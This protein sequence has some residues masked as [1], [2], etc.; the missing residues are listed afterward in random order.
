[1]K[2]E[3]AIGEATP[4]YLYDPEVPTRIHHYIPHAKMIAILR[5]PVDRAYSHFLHLIRDGYEPIQDFTLALQTEEK[6]MRDNWGPAYHYKNNG[7]Y[8]SQ[9]QRYLDVFDKK[10]IKIYLYEDFSTHPLRVLQDIFRF[11]KVDDQSVPDLSKKHN[12]SGFPRKKALHTLL[13]MRSPI[14]TILAPFVPSAIRQRL[15]H[16]KEKNLM[17]PPPLSSE[18]RKNLT[19]IFRKDILKLQTLIERD[20]SHWLA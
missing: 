6:R 2:N 1:V 9:I 15:V 8:A 4:R 13:T 16:L 3:L 20:L 11:L 5:N 7:F 19:E 12:E 14:R 18:I 17:K 10:Q